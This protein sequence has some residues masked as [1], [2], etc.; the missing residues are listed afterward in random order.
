MSIN[1]SSCGGKVKPNWDKIAIAV[2]GSA[3]MIPLAALVGLKAGLIALCVAAW[4]GNKSAV[5]LLRLKVKLMEASRRQGSFF[6][7]G[8]CGRHASVEEVFN[9]LT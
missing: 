7:C 3:V 9:Q 5:H 6:V 4:G 8:S 2:G 1:C